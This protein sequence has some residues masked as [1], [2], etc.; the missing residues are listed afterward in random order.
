M[1]RERTKRRLM[2]F[3]IFL[4]IFVIGGYSIFQAQKLIQGPQIAIHSPPDGSVSDV[5][6]IEITGQTKNLTRFQMNDRDIY[7]DEEGKFKEKFL[8]SYGY[9]IIRLDGWDK[10]DRQTEKTLEIIYR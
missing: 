3:G 8:L 10:F 4:S 9:N 2:W 1:E 5:S 6:L 7:K